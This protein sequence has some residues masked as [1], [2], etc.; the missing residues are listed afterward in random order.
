M[1]SAGHSKL[2]L[3]VQVIHAY[4]R[5][6]R[7]PRL[8]SE[9]CRHYPTRAARRCLLRYGARR[10]LKALSADNNQNRYRGGEMRDKLIIH[11]D[12]AG[13]QFETTVDRSE[14][15]TSELQ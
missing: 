14:E 5:L 6:R 15:H 7:H 11:H 8:P 1:D 12:R 3:E 10:M 9:E 13:H 4:R 2:H